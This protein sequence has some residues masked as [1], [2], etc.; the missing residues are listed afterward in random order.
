VHDFDFVLPEQA[1]D[2]GK[3]AAVALGAAYYPL[4]ERRQT[5]RVILNRSNA[6]RLIL[7]FALYRG[8]DLVSDLRGRD[9]TIN[10]IALDL[11]KPDTL[12]D[13]LVGGRDLLEKRL[14]ACS[15]TTFSDDPVRTLRAIRFSQQY[16]LRIEVDTL[17][18]LRENA[19]QIQRV[20]SER[21]RDEVFKMLAGPNPSTMIRLMDRMDLLPHVF[22]ELVALKGVRQT[23]PHQQDVWEHTLD[24]LGRVEAVLVGLGMNFNEDASGNLVMGLM[25][26]QL[27]RY[28]RQINEHLS[29]TLT[30]DRSVRSLLYLS[31]LLHDTGKPSTVQNDQDGMIHFYKHELVSEKLA[32]NRGKALYLSNAEIV[33]LAL[34]VRHHMRL[35]HLIGSTEKISRRALYRFFR[36]CGEAGIDVCLL[37]LADVLAIYGSALPQEL[38]SRYLGYVRRVFEAWW[39]QPQLSVKPPPLINGSDIMNILNVSPG[40]LI[41]ELLE[42]IREA[43]AVGEVETKDQAISLAKKWLEIRG[44]M[45]ESQ[46]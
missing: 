35:H 25:S 12:I 4:D 44:R 40:P 23:L 22:P 19:A 36:D 42:V 32:V 30:P 20:T 46:G 31:A 18:S 28:R 27:G 33:R 1:L 26:L 45:P 17:R 39:E 7:D 43:Q 3:K 5:A 24:V 29:Q 16:Q 34:I 14:R 41:G 13:P 8:A 38:W 11:R 15:P 9:F 6:E 21:V 10:A 37:T 2:I